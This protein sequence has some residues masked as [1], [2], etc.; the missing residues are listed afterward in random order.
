MSRI[1]TSNVGTQWELL[2]E[3]QYRP[4]Q[5]HQNADALSRRPCDDRCKWCKSWKSQK[6]VSFVDVGIQTE[7]QVPNQDNE[8]LTSCESP[9]GDHCAMMKLEPMWTS[10]FLRENRK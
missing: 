1:M 9:V 5:R 3:I 4:E 7:M 2:F 6:Q 8:Q 10:A